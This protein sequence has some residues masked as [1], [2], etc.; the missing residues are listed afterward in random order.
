MPP[1]LL[2]AAALKVLFDDAL[3][4]KDLSSATIKSLSSLLRVMMNQHLE[5]ACSVMAQ[6]AQVYGLQVRGRRSDR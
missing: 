3:A 2:P 4:A 6:M 1:A 5:W